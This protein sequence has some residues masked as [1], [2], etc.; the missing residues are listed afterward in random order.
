MIR[1]N[2][3]YMRL[4]VGSPVVALAAGCDQARSRSAPSCMTDPERPQYI[5]TEIGIGYRLRYA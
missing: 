1:S 4:D 3:I 5:M 2:S